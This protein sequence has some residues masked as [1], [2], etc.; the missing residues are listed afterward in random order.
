MK[1]DY[2]IKAVKPTPKEW[3][4]QYGPM[5]TWLIQVEG[6][7]EPVQLNKKADSPQPKPGDRIY[8][9][10]EDTEYGQKFKGAPRPPGASGYQKSPEEREGM[11]RCNALN[12]AVAIFTDGTGTTPSGEIITDLADKFY[13]WLKGESPA[14]AE[15]TG[16]DK[17]K[18]M[19]A[20]LK[21]PAIG[22]EIPDQPDFESAEEMP[23]DWLK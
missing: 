11:Y 4:S 22:K 23:E 12:N 15:A 1:Q 18:A 8:G 10:I 13:A 20:Q 21:K 14:P 9:H 2:T 5:L 16:Y 6:N 3:Q 7:G 17:A 19:A